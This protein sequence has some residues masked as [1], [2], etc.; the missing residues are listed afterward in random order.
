MIKW[1]GGAVSSEPGQSDHATG[2]A[3]SQ[4]LVH[5]GR[6][7]WARTITAPGPRL[8]QVREYSLKVQIKGML[9]MQV[10]KN[11]IKISLVFSIPMLKDRIQRG[12]VVHSISS[13]PE[14]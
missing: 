9:Y 13:N 6:L 4:R 1:S 2:M 8:V 12:R 14:A 3:R 10:M 11:D 7:Q 5:A